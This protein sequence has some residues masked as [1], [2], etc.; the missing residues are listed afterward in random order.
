KAA[1]TKAKAKSA[2]L[3]ASLI[4]AKQKHLIKQGLAETPDLHSEHDQTRVHAPRAPP[5]KRLLSKPEVLAIAGVTY[6]TVCAWRRNVTF[7]RSGVV[8]GR[9][10]WL[11]TEVEAWLAELPIRPLKGDVAGDGQ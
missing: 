6:P 11:S 5:D 10:M 9:S 1:A 3:P 8:G 2:A 4:A 7:P